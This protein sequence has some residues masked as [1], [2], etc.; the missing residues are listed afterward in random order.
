MISAKGIKDGKELS[1]TYDGKEFVIKPDKYQYYES[2]IRYHLEAGHPIGG[3]YYTELK[4]D[5]L[6]VTEVLSNWFFDKPVTVE[7]DVNAEIPWEKEVV[8]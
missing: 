2:D 7:S 5:Y 3:T 6:N 4:M 8:Y 1:V